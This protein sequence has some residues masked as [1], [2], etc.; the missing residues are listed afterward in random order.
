M[1]DLYKDN[2]ILVWLDDK[3]EMANVVIFAHSL[4][5]SLPTKEMVEVLRSLAR[6]SVELKVRMERN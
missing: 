5:L 3:G 1:E 4:C 2:N 6:A